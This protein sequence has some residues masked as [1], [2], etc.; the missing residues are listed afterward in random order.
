MIVIL[1]FL[2][3]A[4]WGGFLAKRRNGSR[5][6]VLQYATAF[7][8]AFAIVGLFATVIVERML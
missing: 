6:D 8:V 3:G 1:A 5:L 4:L 7:A 2:A